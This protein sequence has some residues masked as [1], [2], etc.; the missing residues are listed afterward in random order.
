MSVERLKIKALLA[1]ED[2][3]YRAAHKDARSLATMELKFLL[4]WAF[5]TGKG[6][7]WPFDVF[8]RSLRE[9]PTA[10]QDFVQRD[11][12]LNRALNGI[13]LHLGVFRSNEMMFARVRLERR[14][15]ED[16]GAVAVGVG[17]RS[18]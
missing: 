2:L 8:W 9:N 1:L 5:E 7:R 15:T 14:A 4:A 12:D 18:N 13:Y 16:A 6:D 3:L 11:G 17:F 10:Y